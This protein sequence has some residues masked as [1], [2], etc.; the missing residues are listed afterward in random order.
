MEQ[1]QLQNP[2]LGA[3]GGANF[4]NPGDQSADK[5]HLLPS[6][7]S[8]NGAP[9]PI[10]Q[11]SSNDTPQRLPSSNGGSKDGLWANLDGGTEKQINS[12]LIR[13][14]ENNVG[15]FAAGKPSNTPSSS[16]SVKRLSVREER[17]RLAHSKI[18]CLIIFM[19]R[20][21]VLYTMPIFPL[22]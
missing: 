3:G 21:M 13:S 10:M 20:A 1:N 8:W 14:D 7:S 6:Q 4:W 16:S 5:A 22:K 12:P 18:F 2:P 11:G 19:M 15:L 17:E 9:S